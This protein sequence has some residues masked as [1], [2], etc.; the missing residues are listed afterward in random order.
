[1][2]R[3]TVPIELKAEEAIAHLE[4]NAPDILEEF[5]RMSPA[6]RSLVL[7]ENMI[8]LM[9]Q[10]TEVANGKPTDEQRSLRADLLRA[11]LEL[12]LHEVVVDMAKSIIGPKRFDQLRSQGDTID[13]NTMCPHEIELVG[14]YNQALTCRVDARSR[15]SNLSMVLFEDI[16]EEPVRKL[17]EGLEGLKEDKK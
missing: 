3:V 7:T 6:S 17:K 16:L 10:V 4:K 5:A 13:G 12:M 15:M 9:F 14:A 8:H 11:T 1:V 2:R